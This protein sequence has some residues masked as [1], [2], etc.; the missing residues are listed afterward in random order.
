MPARLSATAR[1]AIESSGSD[2]FVSAVSVWEI[3]IKRATGKLRA[4]ADLV[5]RATDAA[6]APLP[7]EWRHGTA[8]GALPL[9]PRDPFDRML[10]AQAQVEGLT[11]V[12]SDPKIAQY[13]VAVLAAS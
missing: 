12:T 10:V 4:P 5:S 3:E 6:F 2:V 8:A 11:L 13:P 7:V 1:E 9:P